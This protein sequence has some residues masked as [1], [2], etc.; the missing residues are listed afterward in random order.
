MHLDA[1]SLAAYSDGELSEPAAGQAARHL[2]TCPRCAQEAERIR[3]ERELSLAADA[4]FRL[5][6][7]PPPD[8]LERV[9]GCIQ[10]WLRSAAGAGGAMPASSAAELRRRIGAHLELYFGSE[11]AALLEK[12]APSRRPADN[13]IT[14]VEPLLTAFLGRKA[15]GAA[16][17]Q[18]LA[19]GEGRQ[20]L[21]PDAA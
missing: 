9:R 11:T 5:Q 13:P 2:E 14:A 21:A 6:C 18:I 1:G 15:A 16:I 20:T 8:G 4:L 7:V 17:R 10:D 3:G 19:G 12:V